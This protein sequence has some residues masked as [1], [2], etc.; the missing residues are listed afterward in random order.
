MDLKMSWTLSMLDLILLVFL[1]TSRM[2]E[3]SLEMRKEREQSVSR[4]KSQGD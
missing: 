4:R 3:A 1:S 2:S